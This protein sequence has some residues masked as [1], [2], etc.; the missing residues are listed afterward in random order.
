VPVFECLALNPIAF[1]E[2][3]PAVAKFENPDLTL[4]ILAV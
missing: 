4:S 2:I 3:D 1:I